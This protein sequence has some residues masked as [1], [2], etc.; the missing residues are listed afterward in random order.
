MKGYSLVE[1]MIATTLATLMSLGVVSI[2]VNQ[3]GTISTETQRD[4]ALQV[5]NQSFDV[6]SR[7]LRQ[8]DKS[9]IRINYPSGSGLNDDNSPEI[10]NDAISVDFLIPSGFNIWPNDT[11]PYINNAIRLSWTNSSSSDSALTLQMAKAETLDGLAGRPLQTIAGSNTD[12]QARIINLDVWPMLDQRN[13][14][15]SASA[16]AQAGYMVKITTRTAQADMAYTNPLDPD[17]A[18]KPY[19]THTVSGIIFPRN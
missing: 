2:F 10:E 13:P 8:A 16:A 9:S 5:A 4:M 3:T 6:V 18:L 7:L 14:Q 19:R 12:D 1:L 11:P 17:G 15:A